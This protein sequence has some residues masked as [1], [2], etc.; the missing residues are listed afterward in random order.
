MRIATFRYPRAAA[1]APLAF[2]LGLV[3]T[4]ASGVPALGQ[5]HDWPGTVAESLQDGDGDAAPVAMGPLGLIAESVFG[6]AND[7][8][9]PLPLRT[10]FSEGWFEPWNYPPASSG[11]APRQGWINGLNGVFFRL[12]VFDFTYEND[13]HKNGNG[14]LGTYTI[15]VPVSRR[16]QVRLDVPF[17]ESN[18]GGRSDSYHGNFGDLVVSSRFLLS[19]S[20][21]LSQVFATVIRTPTGAAENGNP[22]TT[23]TPQYEFWYG[24]L[25]AGWVVR[26]GTGVTVPVTNAG[27][28][29]TA[30]YDLAL[31]KYWTPHDAAPF[32]D[33]VTYLAVDGSSTLDDRGRRHSFL[34]L[35]PGLRTHLGDDWYFLFGVDVPVTGPK[36]LNYAWA[37]IV[38]FMKVY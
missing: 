5:A 25:P 1:F 12:F 2:A 28:R 16:F 17:I 23:L 7:P 22:Q 26:G 14:Y 8:W 9:R 24:G 27:A 11:G 35:T 34:S 21:D 20:Q 37:P 38:W 13:L 29:T 15:F 33:F 18:K 30:N 6:N 32:G 10:F 4:V 3:A 31:G 19:E 36:S